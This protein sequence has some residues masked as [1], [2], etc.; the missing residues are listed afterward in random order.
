MAVW[1]WAFL[2]VG[3]AYG[4]LVLW[5]AWVKG[6]VKFGPLYYTKQAN[7]IYFWFLVVVFFLCETYFVGLTTLLVI[8][9]IVGPLF[10]QRDCE[11]A[12][13]WKAA[14][15]CPRSPSG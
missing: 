1:M 7:P 4:A 3:I 8:S 11:N 6:F 9:L 13:G 5:R 12:H 10:D 14:L 2:A 15:L